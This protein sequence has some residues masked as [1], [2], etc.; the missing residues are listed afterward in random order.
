MSH[1][2]KK[3]KPADLFDAAAARYAK[4]RALQQVGAN[5]GSWMDDA[6]AQIGLLPDG[7]FGT[8]ED[9]RL[10]LEAKRIVP[11]HCNA[12]GALIGTAQRRHLIA[13]T[14]QWVPMSGSKSNARRTPV[15]RRR[16]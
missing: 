5:S 1:K 7:W 8:G 13:Q 9:I 16:A 12:W 15:Y 10:M 11:H 3:P 14:G 2:N 4:E 6:L